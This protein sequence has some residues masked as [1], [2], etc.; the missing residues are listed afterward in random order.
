MK[1]KL[2]ILKI[3]FS[4]INL[5]EASAG[6]GKTTTIALLYL[7]LLLG[8][9]EE[10]KIG[11]LLVQEILVVTFTNAA[12]EELYIRI[13]ENIEKL[14][15]SC[16]NK[17]SEDPIFGYFL[18][19]IKNLEKAISILKKAKTNINNAAIYTIHG[20]C[21]DIFKYSSF[22][23]NKKIIENESFLYLQAT[24]DFWRYL[25]YNLPKN[26]IEII[27]EEYNNPDVL[28]KEIKAILTTNSSIQF[29]KKFHKNQ[30]LITFHENII[31]KINIFKKKWLCYYIKIL[32]IISQSKVNKR[33]YHES[34]IFKWQKK[35]TQWAQSKTKNYKIPIFLKYFSKENIEKKT[36]YNIQE[37]HFFEDIEKILKKN[38]SLKSI[39]LFYAIKNIPKFIKKEKE[40]KEL[41]GFDDLL[42]ILLKK[43]KK[44]KFLRKL[45]IKKYPIALI[46]EFQDTNITQYQIFNTLY[47]NE[48]TALFLVGDPK[49]SIYSFRGADIFT[50]LCAKSKIKNYY[51]LDINW[52]SSIHMCK[53]INYLFSRNKNSFYF[54]NIPFQPVLPSHKNINMQFKIKG[55][56]QKAIHIFFKK[57]EKVFIEEYQDW[58]GK[59][60][61]NEISYWLHCSKNG[62]AIIINKDQEE[63]KVTEEDIV[64]LVKNKK[65]AKIII[66]SLKKVNIS[67]TYSSPH[68]NI[69]QTFD[70]YE[71]LTILKSIA[72]PTDIKLL[73]KSILIHILNK[74]I[75]RK[76]RE[77]K[78]EKI[79]YLLIEKLYKYNNIWKKIGIFH[80]IKTMIL[81]Y[82]KY[83]NDVELYTNQQKNVNFLHIAE[84]LEKQCEECYTHHAL[85]RWFEKKI[86]EKNIPL[87]NENVRNIQKNKSIKIIS[88]HKSKGLQY[89]IVWIPFSIDFKESKL[90]LYHDRKTSKKIF[91]NNKNPM[92]LKK[93]DEERLAED[94]RFLYV[95]LTRAMYHC[96][97]GIASL[98]KYKRQKREGNDNDIHKSALGYIIKGGKVIN[99]KELL[100]ELNLLN[101]KIYFELKYEEIKLKRHFSQNDIYLLSKPIFLLKKIESSFQ[102]T[103]FTQLKKEKKHLDNCQYKYIKS[104]FYKKKDEKPTIHNFPRGNETGIL[105]HK[106]LKQINFHV[107]LNINYFSFMLKKNGFSEIWTP[108]LISWINNIL[109]L[110]LNHLK[111]TLGTLKQ[112]KYAKELEFYLS[113]KNKFNKKFF[114]EIVH[115]FKINSNSIDS[116][117]YLHPVSGVIKGFIDLVFVWKKRYYI[118]DYK[119]NY[120]GE[121]DDYYSFKNIEKEMIENQYNLQYQL[122]TLALHQYLKKKIKT[123][124]YTTHFGGIFYIFLRGINTKNSIFYCVPDYSLIKKLMYLFSI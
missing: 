83:A 111:I 87:D 22:N 59:Q 112:T 71:L 78:K 47:N 11:K 65:E 80:T 101:K 7:R 91:D 12:K 16:I 67:S 118:V 14:Y 92:T 105:I 38:F 84:L 58:I 52:R 68:K 39:I 60:C 31:N 48:K 30:N 57:K 45:I 44:E 70:A 28:L 69:F 27:Y 40:K 124:H 104:I 121:N 72:N 18:K 115:S 8:L 120:L 23:L 37:H 81:E 2:N 43:I 6:T 90:Y 102:I 75:I 119:S 32:K 62:R 107:P 95:S 99:Y 54:E 122:Y 9:T 77:Q 89:P 29:K 88:I 64:V 19:K 79:S 61:A 33:I 66:D 98:I 35:I 13:K 41:L 50:Y 21:Q 74:I 109:N 1:K 36:N 15:I 108:I 100:Y 113:I 93:S 114:N 106:I 25:F 20:F 73:K 49:Q 3:P 116:K 103:S 86:L 94:L 123:Y 17:K 117:I 4:G 76:I 26:I 97:I 85:I 55:E 96:S 51:Y 42:E 10:K 63:K 110:K 53:A 46:D 24:Q 56:A 82:Q 5:I 34:N